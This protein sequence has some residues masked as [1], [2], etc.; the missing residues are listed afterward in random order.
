MKYPKI[1]FG[2]LAL[3]G[4]LGFSACDD[5][6]D[7]TIYT[8][9][10]LE[11]VTTG[12][13]A[14]TA[15]TATVTGTVRDLSSMDPSRFQVGVIYSTDRDAVTSSG[16]RASGALGD[17]G[18]TVTTLVS[19][20]QPNV[21]Y[22]YAQY[23]ILQGKYSQY[24]EVQAFVTSDAKVN[25]ID[26]AEVTR[27]GAVLGCALNQ[28]DDLLAA[29]A[30]H[31]VLL[32]T[33]SSLRDAMRY[34]VESKES[35]FSVTVGGLMPG[36]TYYYAPYL[37][38]NG[39]ETLGEVKSFTTERGTADVPESDEYVDMGVRMH[40]AKCN[41]GAETE[42]QPGGLYGY[43]DIT[44]LN[45]STAAAD[46]AEGEISGTSADPAFAAGYGQMPTA[47]DWDDLLSVS[48][49][50][51]EEIDGVK[52]VRLTS[53]KNGNSIFLPLAG[54]RS[55]EEVTAADIKGI[56][57][58]ATPDARNSEYVTVYA[59]D[60]TAA[61]VDRAHRSAGVS[62]RAIRP[63]PILG[64]LPFE[65][66]KV[67]TGDLE[68]KGNYRIELFNSYGPTA[69]DPAIIP[70]EV[71]FEKNL[72]VTFS[73]SGLD[74]QEGLGSYVASLIYVDGSWGQ[75]YWGPADGTYTSNEAIVNA[76]G[77][78]RVMMTPTGAAKGCTMMFVEIKNLAKDIDATAVK[79]EV[80]AVQVDLDPA[81]QEI[82]VDNSKVLFNNKDGN[83][84]DGRIEIYNEYGE[85]KGLGA[86]YSGIAFPAGTMH[87]TFSI[88]GIDGNLKAGAPTS[89]PAAISFADA[90]WY[91]GYWGGACGDGA[92]TG[93]GTYTLAAP[94][95]ADCEGA[96][97]WCIELYQLWANLVDTSKVKVS[98][99]KVIVPAP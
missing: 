22:Y 90:D 77:T 69:N 68:E 5:D 36:Q 7:V 16:T 79:A 56:Y 50:A 28:V 51:A 98:V 40:W 52:G 18:F 31:G 42:G 74:G 11:E 41:L 34:P 91:P 70:D 58:A 8:E 47:A 94:L 38:M 78:Y 99:D 32:G 60:G 25:T 61:T 23:V 9:P 2:A 62:I 87:I 24:G 6:D 75:Q 81:Q 26:A 85:T 80:L 76:D 3:C 96:V 59:F 10:I 35:N 1:L 83:G 55:G 86:D 89:F 64:Q 45:R 27:T 43:G 15:T 46:Y 44:G 63:R 33:N 14:T 95:I 97:V 17:D 29:G 20:L 13:A 57:A 72:V 39:E 37:E 65:S 54:M 12:S 4:L 67:Q 48:T 49:I 92:I 88:S 30:A 84:T 82:A 73:L 93:D 19:G 66:D 53:T 21:T 71:A